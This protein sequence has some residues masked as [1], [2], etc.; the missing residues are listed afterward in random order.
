MSFFK[1]HSER[2]NIDAFRYNIEYLQNQ[3]LLERQ[4]S[5]IYVRGEE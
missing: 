3:T 2:K 5:E 4:P 1:S